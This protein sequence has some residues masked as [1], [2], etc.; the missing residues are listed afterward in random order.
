MAFSIN[1]AT[2]VGN[3]S[4]DI[5]LKSTNNGNSVVNFSLATNRSI[6]NQDGS[7]T[8]VATFHRVVVWGKLAE[9]VARDLSKGSKVFVEGRIDNRSYDDESGVKKYISEIVADHVIGFGEKK[10][11]RVIENGQA[12]DDNDEIQLDLDDAPKPSKYK[13]VSADDIPF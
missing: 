4:S 7:Y 2:L 10:Q 6:K 13:S 5:T 3:I 1:K 9:W 8:D 11:T 12:N